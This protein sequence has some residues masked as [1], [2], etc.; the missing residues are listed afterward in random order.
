M[1]WLEPGARVNIDEDWTPRPGGWGGPGR[2]GGRFCVVRWGHVG[3][4]QLREEESR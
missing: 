1:G 3:L 2:N 4:L